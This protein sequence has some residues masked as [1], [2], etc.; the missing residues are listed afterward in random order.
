MESE[1]SQA[2]AR[3]LQAGEQSRKAQCDIWR[4]HVSIVKRANVLFG[5]CKTDTERRVMM[6]DMQ[7]QAQDFE[8]AIASQCR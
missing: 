3:L 5:R 7:T 1:L 6:G 8:E 4:Q 2:K